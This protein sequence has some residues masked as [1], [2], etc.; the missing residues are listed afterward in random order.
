MLLEDM[1]V[2]GQ[3]SLVLLLVVAPC[4]DGVLNV[5]TRFAVMTQ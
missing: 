2:M 4:R 5:P 3:Q 1:T